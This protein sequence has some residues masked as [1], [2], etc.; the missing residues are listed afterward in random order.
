MLDEE[1]SLKAALREWKTELGALVRDL[2]DGLPPEKRLPLIFRADGARQWVLARVAERDA[3]IE[4]LRGQLRSRTVAKAQED[5]EAEAKFQRFHARYP[6]VCERLVD[7]AHGLKLKGY[8]RFGMK[9]LFERLRWAG[10][11][12]TA[13]LGALDNS[14]TS[15]FARLIMDTEP[16]LAGFFEVRGNDASTAEELEALG[17]LPLPLPQDQG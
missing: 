10:G 4:R 12:R 5:R 13:G 8:L 3:E 16:D 1:G 14:Y 9:A 15:R 7:L 6:A 11:P 2:A 17:Q